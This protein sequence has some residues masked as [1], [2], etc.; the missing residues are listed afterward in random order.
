MPEFRTFA[1]REIREPTFEEKLSFRR[2]QEEGVADVMVPLADAP[3]HFW[4]AVSQAISWNLH[5]LNR[6]SIATMPDSFS[7]EVAWVLGLE[8]GYAAR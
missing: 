7:A 3:Q 1:D 2:L 4:N 8:P 5:S 6:A